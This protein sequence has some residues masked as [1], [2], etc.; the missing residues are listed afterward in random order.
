MNNNKKNIS[1]HIIVSG[2]FSKNGNFIGKDANGESIHI[3]KKQMDL[4]NLKSN[5]DVVFPLF[6]IGVVK[7]FTRLKGELG[8][9]ERE[10][11]I[12]DD[13][14]NE[15][16]ERLTAMAVFK[17]FEN[18]I[19]VYAT[20]IVLNSDFNLD[21]VNENN[22]KANNAFKVYFEYRILINS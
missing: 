13:G 8:D 22:I 10:I 9:S 18:L 6:A 3:Y 5:E 17:K 15:T 4:K 20:G 7:V 12:K 11:A 21:T 14:S 16:F 1:H 2:H 19:D